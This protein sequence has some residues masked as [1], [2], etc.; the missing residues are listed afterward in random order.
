MRGLFFECD[1][2]LYRPAQDG[3]LYYWQGIV[4]QQVTRDETGRLAFH[5]VCRLS[6]PA[7]NQLSRMHT[8]NRYKGVTVVDMAACQHPHI[9]RV[10]VQLKKHFCVIKR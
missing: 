9:A 5:E 10:A 2:R 1:G 6:S 4:I 8:L 3:K 7:A